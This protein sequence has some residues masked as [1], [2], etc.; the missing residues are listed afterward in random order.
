MSK[1]LR[2][3]LLINHKQLNQSLFPIKVYI[4]INFFKRPHELLE[5]SYNIHVLNYIKFYTTSKTNSQ[6]THYSLSTN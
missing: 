5:E 4:T 2:L 1:E 3:S 6:K